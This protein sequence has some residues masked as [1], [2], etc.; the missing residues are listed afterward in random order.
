MVVSTTSY[1][2]EHAAAG[3]DFPFPNIKTWQNQFAGYEILVD[4]PEFTRCA[5]K[6]ACPTLAS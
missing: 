6:P 3:L 4:D 5:Q 1:T 2:D